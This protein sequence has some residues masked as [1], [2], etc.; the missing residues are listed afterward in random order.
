MNFVFG[1]AAGW[2]NENSVLVVILVLC[3]Y[4]LFCRKNDSLERWMIAGLFGLITG[5]GLLMLAPGNMARLYAEH[6]SSSWNIVS[7]IL[8]NLEVLK[9]VFIFQFFLW[10]F[11]LRG[12]FTL[13]KTDKNNR[14]LQRNVS[15]AKVIVM[16]SFTMSAIMLFSP[17]FPARSAFSGTIYLIMAAGILLR[18]QDEFQITIITGSAKK[19]LFCVCM[20][21]FIFTA[22]YSLRN[23]YYTN[24]QVQELIDMVEKTD[25]Q[26]RYKVLIVKKIKQPSD[27][28]NLLTG[29]HV[30]SHQ[31]SEDETDWK[32]V[33]LARY[34]AVKG[35]RAVESEE[36][37]YGQE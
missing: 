15:F 34:Y 22:G 36:Y 13:R 3:C 19:F 5:Y 6:N 37:G 14:L 28:E 9:S 2:T 25:D 32:N 35:I 23:Y 26:D 18:I 16:V 30:L 29:F 4:I 7:G 8:K 20:T 24:L 21:Y 31:L 33:A 10:Y 27:Q 12:L 17:A 11:V 1:V